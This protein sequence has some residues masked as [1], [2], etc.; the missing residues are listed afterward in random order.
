MHFD[1]LA[2]TISYIVFPGRLQPWCSGSGWISRSMLWSTIQTAMLSH[3]SQTHRWAWRTFLLQPPLAS[4]PWASRL[5]LLRGLDQWCRYSL[6]KYSVNFVS[7]IVKSRQD[8]GSIFVTSQR[9]SIPMVVVVSTQFLVYTL[10][11]RDLFVIK[12]QSPFR[13]LTLLVQC[14][15]FPYLTLEVGST[16]LGCQQIHA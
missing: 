4:R 7:K 14:C 15:P 13:T 9:A 2:E 3:L 6:P 1:S 8:F 10:I 11:T 5:S 16:K 12:S